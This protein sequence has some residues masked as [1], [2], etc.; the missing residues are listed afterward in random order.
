LSP[1]PSLTAIQVPAGAPPLLRRRR[2]PETPPTN[3][4]PPID[5]GWVESTIPATCLRGRAPPRRRR[6]CSRRRVRGGGTEG[7][8]VKISKVLGFVVQNDSSL[9]CELVQHLVKLIK[10]R[11]KIQK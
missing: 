7:I 6:A 3:P 2:S 1:G 5:H 11:R 8:S 10:N 4:P 9:F